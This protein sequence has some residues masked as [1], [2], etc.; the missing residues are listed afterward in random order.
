MRIGS[1]AV[2]DTDSWYGA[3]L[4]NPSKRRVFKE[5]VD[6]D[7]YWKR[8]S[9][10]G[11][12]TTDYP[13]KIIICLAVVK[14]KVYGVQLV[15]IKT[16]EVSYKIKFKGLRAGDLFARKEYYEEDGKRV[17]KFSEHHS[18]EWFME[19]TNREAYKL[20]WGDFVAFAEGQISYIEVC[21]R[22]MVAG[23]GALGKSKTSPKAARVVE[24]TKR[25]GRDVP[26]FQVGGPNWM[27]VNPPRPLPGDPDP[28]MPLVWPACDQI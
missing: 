7:V 10:L 15:D 28:V 2:G 11:G 12:L 5:I 1:Y 8:G 21:R 9:D 6:K 18:E 26:G 13:G 23:V 14:K 25:Y 22:Q 24:I 27:G 17:L 20:G 19:H 4:G 16:G 3:L